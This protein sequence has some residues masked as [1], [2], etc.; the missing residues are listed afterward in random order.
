MRQTINASNEWWDKKLNENPKAIKLETK[1]LKNVEQLDIL[2]QDIVVTNEGAS[3]QGFVGQDADD[4]SKLLPNL[5]WKKKNEGR[6]KRKR[7][8]T[9]FEVMAIQLEHICSI[10]ENRSSISYRA[11]KL[12]C[13]IVEVMKIIRGMPEVKNDFELYMKTIDIMVVKENKEMFVA[14]EDPTN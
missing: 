2:F 13:S 9:K 3:S 5:L 7:D 11:D 1:G 8:E 10:V 12:G 14:L 6:R 4:S